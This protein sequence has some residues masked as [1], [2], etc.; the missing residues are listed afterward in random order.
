[1][2]MGGTASKPTVAPAGKR[3]YLED[4]GVVIS[5]NS[6]FRVNVLF[7]NCT[8]GPVEAFWYEVFL[9]GP[10]AAAA[11]RPPK[12]ESRKGVAAGSILRGMRSPTGASRRSTRSCEWG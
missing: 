2:S 6:R 11:I 10:P 12:A 7:H 4:G 1:M 3:H 8:D 5:M 9:Q